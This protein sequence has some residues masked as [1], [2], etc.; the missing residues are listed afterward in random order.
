MNNFTFI[1]ANHCHWNTVRRVAVCALTL[2]VSSVAAAATWE[3]DPV[4]VE[5]SPQQQ[6]AAIKIK[7]NSNQPTKIQINVVAWSQSEGKEVYTQSKELLV[8]PPMVTIAANSEQIIRAALRRHADATNELS[9]RI[10]LQE[11][12][13]Q[14]AP[15]FTGL[16]VA[17]RIGLPVF[18]KPKSGKASPKMLWS[19]TR[20]AGDTL[21]VELHNQ[22]NAHVQVSD[23]ALYIPGEELALVKE[24][25]SS[26]VLAGQA[27]EWLLNTGSPEKVS[28]GRLHLKAFTD[29]GNVDTELVL[30]KP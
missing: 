8:S 15:G 27:H 24:S 4:R 17:L 28:G 6:T 21:K 7:N 14:P 29:A 10:N 2:F 22:G 19:V 11:L 20:I 12:P 18:V 9:Y 30:G 23:F 5:L 25:G 26:Y 3:I 16:Q 1:A 13:A